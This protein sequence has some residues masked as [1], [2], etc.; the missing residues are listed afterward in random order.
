MVVVLYAIA[1]VVLLGGQ[2]VRRYLPGHGRS[3]LIVTLDD[4]QAVEKESDVTQYVRSTLRGA[5]LETLS[6]MDE[7]VSLNY[8]FNRRG[9]F[10]WGLFK[11]NL[12]LLVEPMP[13]RVY[14]G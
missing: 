13:S 3:Y 5:R 8:Q 1:F 4:P 11:K 10:D 9:D 7:G 12:D 6:T 14:I 2:V